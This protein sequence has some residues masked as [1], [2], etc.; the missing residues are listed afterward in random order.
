MYHG[1]PF[2]Q[3]RYVRLSVQALPDISWPLIQAMHENA[4]TCT[5]DMY[6]GGE[7]ISQ[8]EVVFHLEAYLPLRL[9]MILNGRNIRYSMLMMRNSMIMSMNLLNLSIISPAWYRRI[10]A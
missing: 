4:D 5:I 3:C 7:Q 8:P 10:L 2:G 6:P 1:R 9:Y